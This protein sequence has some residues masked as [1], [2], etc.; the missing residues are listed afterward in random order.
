MSGE[1]GR[2]REEKEKSETLAVH[3]IGR[4][5]ETWKSYKAD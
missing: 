3:F 1:K 2:I 4:G 5:I